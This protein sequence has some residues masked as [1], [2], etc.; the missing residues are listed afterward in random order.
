MNDVEQNRIDLIEKIIR[1]TTDYN[2]TNGVLGCPG[3][4]AIAALNA[5]GSNEESDLIKQGKEQ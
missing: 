4:V 1:E 3:D 2:Q 5:L